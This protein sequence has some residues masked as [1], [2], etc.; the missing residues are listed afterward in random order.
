MR[1]SS[2][3]TFVFEYVI[4]NETVSTVFLVQKES[5]PPLKTNSYFGQYAF[6][7]YLHKYTKP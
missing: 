5:H 1:L 4:A 7:N 6:P 3:A 2:I